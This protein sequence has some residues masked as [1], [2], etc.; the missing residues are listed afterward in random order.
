MNLNDLEDNGLKMNKYWSKK[1]YKKTLNTLYDV[2]KNTL[3][4]SDIG[5]KIRTVKK[6]GR[7][8]LVSDRV[9]IDGTIADEIS[10][11]LPSSASCFNIYG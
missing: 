7:I 11:L 5:F 2:F 8:E 6:T 1:D 9:F 4:L 10:K 3:T